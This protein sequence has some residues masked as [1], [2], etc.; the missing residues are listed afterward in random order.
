M[1]APPS[2][3]AATPVSFA[4]LGN[5]AL[6]FGDNDARRCW[7]GVVRRA[8]AAR[9]VADMQRALAAV[10]TYTAGVDGDFGNGTREAL[11]RFQ[12]YVAHVRHRL[13]VPAGGG[14]A[15]GVFED[16]ARNMA[17]TLTGRCDAQ[18]A[19]ELI[20]WG[21]G[22]ARVTT[23]LV[24]VPMSRF[25]HIARSETFTT[26]PYPD[27]KGDEVLVN[28]GFAVGLD[29]LD[30]AAA[31]AGVRLHLNQTY[32]RQDVPPTG[33]VVPPATRSQHLI[34]QAVDLNVIDG[35]TVVTSAMFLR[36]TATQSALAVVRAARNAGLRWGGDFTQKDP[37]HFDLRIAADHEDYA[38]NFFFCQH[39]FALG[40]PIRLL[41]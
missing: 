30:R 14:V 22:G 33:A 23:P 6:E 18:T 10:G 13:C 32:R 17:V 16:Y 12:W 3:N 7:G 11:R 2:D 28:A 29:S 24:R 19:A 39:C 38:M 36:N 37:V 15:D 8:Q 25:A 1:A 20:A 27:A 5:V 21:S 4:S 9:P 34:G 35:A 31:G 41:A 26:L 40:H